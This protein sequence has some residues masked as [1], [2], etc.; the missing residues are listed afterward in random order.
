[1]LVL[2]VPLSSHTCHIPCFAHPLLCPAMSLM[3]HQPRHGLASICLH[4]KEVPNAQ[5]WGCPSNPQLPCPSLP[6][7]SRL[8]P[9]RSHGETPRFPGLPFLQPLDCH[10]SQLPTASTAVPWPIPP[11]VGKQNNLFC[12]TTCI[13]TEQTSCNR[14]WRESSKN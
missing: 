9:D 11:V 4:L 14:L 7:P 5:R 13:K 12:N 10:C 8:C 2:K 6:P 1:M 3:P